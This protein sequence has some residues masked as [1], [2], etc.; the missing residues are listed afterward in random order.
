[1]RDKV[2]DNLDNRTD[3]KA[4][5]DRCDEKDDIV[6]RRVREG[7][8]GRMSKGVEDALSLLHNGIM[9]NRAPV[10]RQC[11]KVG[12]ILVSRGRARVRGWGGGRKPKAR[13]VH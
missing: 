6:F 13:V 8:L 2:N 1:M 10:E 7:D 9:R 11:A 4:V 5:Q 3:L 12:R